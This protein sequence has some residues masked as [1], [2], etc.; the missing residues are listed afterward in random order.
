MKL[1]DKISWLMG[2]VQRSLFPH[3]DE[4]LETP[5]T[6]QKKRLVT[7]L[8]IVQV[9]KHVFTK[10]PQI[11]GLVVRILNVKPWSDHLLPIICTDTRQPET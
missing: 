5:L 6:E 4:C 11:S 10:E 2:S 3:L 7:V 9:E 1:T 8:E